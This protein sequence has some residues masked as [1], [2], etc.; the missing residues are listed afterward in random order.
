MTCIVGIEVNEK[1]AK[2]ANRRVVIGGDMQGSSWNHKAA[3]TQPKVFEKNGIVFGY[4]TSYRFGQLIEHSLRDMAAPKG[5][6]YTWLVQLLVPS[7]REALEAGG[8]KEGGSCIIGVQGEVW[9]L[10][11]DYSVLR[12]TCGYSAVGSG[13]EY[14]LGCLA[15]ITACK[16]L[17]SLDDH[18][19]AVEQAI[20]AA[21]TFSP[22]VGTKSTVVVL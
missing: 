11:E 15:G 2:G 1:P 16:K 4:T 5:D 8:W 3:Y 6:V 22:T 13:S 10:Q 7:I 21:G 17:A 12:S 20:E 9:T 14:A 19:Q 18:V